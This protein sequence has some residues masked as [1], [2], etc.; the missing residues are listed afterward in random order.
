MPYSQP[1]MATCFEVRRRP[2]EPENQEIT[3]AFF[4][5]CEI[6]GRIHR[7]QNV[8]PRNLPIKGRDQPLKAIITYRAVDLPF[9]HGPII[10]IT[11][12]KARSPEDQE[13]RAF[14]K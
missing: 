5:S 7:S 11:N 13:N 14:V 3:E 10:S 9:F 1:G 2:A 12:T 8:I 4:R 6:V